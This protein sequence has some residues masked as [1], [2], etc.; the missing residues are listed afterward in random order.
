VLLSS[1]DMHLFTGFWGSY[2]TEERFG[3]LSR[4]DSAD[5][6]NYWMGTE[7]LSSSSCCCYNSNLLVR[8]WP[9]CPLFFYCW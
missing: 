1:C 9:F 7:L 8:L 2:K 4:G 3:R 5:E 6:Q